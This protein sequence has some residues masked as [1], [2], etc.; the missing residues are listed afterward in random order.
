[1]KSGVL[2]V[3]FSLL[4][5]AFSFFPFPIRQPINDFIEDGFTHLSF[6]FTSNEAAAKKYMVIQCPRL[7]VPETEESFLDLADCLQKLETLNPALVI[8]DTDPGVNAQSSLYKWLQ[9]PLKIVLIAAENGKMADLSF[10]R[11]RDDSLTN[12][13]F[14]FNQ[15]K[16]LQIKNCVPLRGLPT[17]GSKAV[18]LLKGL[19]VPPSPPK[20]IHYFFGNNAYLKFTSLEFSKLRFPKNAFQGKIVLIRT[21]SFSAFESPVLTPIGILT[22]E[23][24]LWNDIETLLQ[25]GKEKNV[26]L[27]VQK[28]FL[29]LF[30]WILWILFSRVNVLTAFLGS[31]FLLEFQLFVEWALFLKGI[32]LDYF[33][34][35]FFPL[36]FLFLLLLWTI[37]SV[38]K[39]QEAIQE[40]ERLKKNLELKNKEL[41]SLKKL[42]DLGK[43]SA[44]IFH[45][46]NN[47]LHNLLNTLKLIAPEEGLSTDSKN[48]L[49]MALEEVKRLQRLSQNLRRLYQSVPEKVEKTVLVNDLLLFSLQVLQ[50]SFNAKNVE[51]ISRLSPKNLE[52][53]AVPDKL[54]QVF[55][56]LLLNALD[57]VPHNGTVWVESDLKDEHILVIIRDSGSG[58]SEKV[59]VKIFEAFFTTKGELGT[60][61]GLYVSFEIVNAL[62]GDIEISNHKAGTHGAEFIVKLP[63]K[64]S[65][66]SGG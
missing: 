66:Y 32:S 17:A 26:S 19:S 46:I 44:G 20:K 23:T 63:R 31:L 49:T 30:L 7:S 15:K 27:P 24:L 45:E 43:L 4:F 58:I 25:G 35:L 59:R 10:R 22:S 61:L 3:L 33:D 38:K 5:C 47:P 51:V 39:Q 29:V 8:L 48:F 18:Q 55:L 12:A 57:A 40:M 34:F 52:V 9:G 2:G 62:G 21:G 54:Q 50:V 14:A 56:N 37:K 60:G 13:V 65:N 11:H 6:R 1:M 41:F 16:N 42:S 28:T 53:Q 64:K 36:L